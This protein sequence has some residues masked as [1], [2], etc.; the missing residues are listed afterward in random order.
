ML[1][2][3]MVLTHGMPWY[4]RSIASSCLTD[5]ALSVSKKWL[6]RRKFVAF[7]SPIT[8]TRSGV[9]GKTGRP[10][11]LVSTGRSPIE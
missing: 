5:W 1:S 3:A 2:A 10:R 8:N 4:S 7:A 11:M 9:Q 6:S